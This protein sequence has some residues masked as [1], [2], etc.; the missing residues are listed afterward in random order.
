M[1]RTYFL[2]H[3]SRRQKRTL[4]FQQDGAP[5]HW[6]LEVRHFLNEQFPNRWI[7]R[8]GPI[9]W[10][11][12]SPDLTPLDFFV[13]GYVRSKVFVPGQQ[14]ANIDQ[15]KYKIEEALNSITPNMLAETF[16]KH[17]KAL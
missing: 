7:G 13:W 16:Q 15:L 8:D 17:S 12:R 9:H 6:G 3:L 1:L 5:P 4:T 11:A 14:I 10:A 2:S